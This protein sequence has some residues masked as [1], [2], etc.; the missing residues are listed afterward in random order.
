MA[1]YNYIRNLARDCICAYMYIWSYINL[2]FLELIC[3]PWLFQTMEYFMIFSNLWYIYWKYI[4]L[5]SVCKC[6]LLKR[7]RK[8][9]LKISISLIFFVKKYLY[10]TFPSY[11]SRNIRNKEHFY[12]TRK[13]DNKVYQWHFIVYNIMIHDM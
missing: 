3:H 8:V 11:W 6:H 5:E 7:Q 9:S 4:P 10:F 12:S 13:Y 1:T 2:F